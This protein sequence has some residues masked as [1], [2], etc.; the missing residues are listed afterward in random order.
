MQ[1]V[2]TNALNKSEKT[3]TVEDDKFFQDIT[4]RLE[5]EAEMLDIP[6]ELEPSATEDG[7]LTDKELGLKQHC[8]YCNK[9]IPENVMT[10]L[11]KGFEPECS[12]CG[13]IIKPKDI[14]ID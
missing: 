14:Q 1:K 10:L 12:N 3:E 7:L 2:S 6:S 5:S 11:R 9:I 8:P 13:E 4:R